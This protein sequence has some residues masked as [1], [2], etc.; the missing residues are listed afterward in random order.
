MLS[1][2]FKR[3]IDHYLGFALAMSFEAL[4]FCVGNIL[5]RDHRNIPV[6]RA[7]VMK[8]SGMGSL[9]CAY[10][11]LAAL[12]ETY[13]GSQFIFWGTGQTNQLARELGIFSEILELDDRTLATSLYSLAKNLIRIWRFRPNWTFDLETY[14]KLSSVLCLLTAARNRAGFVSDTTRFRKRLHTHLVYFNRFR[15]AGELYFRMFSETVGLPEKTSSG[16]GECKGLRIEGSRDADGMV[17]VNINTGELFAPRRWPEE[18]FKALVL[19]LLDAYPNR[20]GFI[21]S[22]SE[23]QVVEG[24]I[25][26][27]ENPRKDAVVN[28]AGKLTL[29]ELMGYLKNAAL[30]ITNDSGPLHLAVLMKTPTIALFGPTHPRHFLPAGGSAEPVYN[31]FICSPCVHVLDEELLPCGK[32]APCM[33]SIGVEEVF[34]AASRILGGAKDAEVPEKRPQTLNT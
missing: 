16:G 15:Y 20:I 26:R 5:R 18:K 4:A 2:K 17:L 21:G 11:A 7:V 12:K 22:R 29:R 14:S 3:K 8:F 34:S 23:R 9:A 6:E 27:L 30:F 1:L 24:F 10:P 32:K 28:L 13:P 33:D 31:D 25:E 19:K